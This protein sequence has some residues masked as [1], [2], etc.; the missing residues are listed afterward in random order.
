MVL[1]HFY[2]N[3]FYI[4]CNLNI[5]TKQAGISRSKPA[6]LGCNM[7]PLLKKKIVEVWSSGRE[8]TDEYVIF[9]KNESY[10]QKSVFIRG[11]AF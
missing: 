6:N 2:L 9:N 3:Y 8:K 5:C 10:L 1:K 4:G 7:L 11:H